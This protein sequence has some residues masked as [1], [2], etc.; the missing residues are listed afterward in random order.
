MAPLHDRPMDENGKSLQAP[1]PGSSATSDALAAAVREVAVAQLQVFLRATAIDEA[2]IVLTGG[3]EREIVATTGGLTGLVGIRCD[4]GTFA[5]QVCCSRTHA[6]M[7]EAERALLGVTSVAGCVVAPIERHGFVYGAFVGALR[8]AGPERTQEAASVAES[9]AIA[10]EALRTFSA[11]QAASIDVQFNDSTR[12][13]QSFSA[14]AA[15]QEAVATPQ[16]GDVF[17]EVQRAVRLAVPESNVVA[18]I[19]APSDAVTILPQLVSVDGAITWSSALRSVRVGDCAASRAL[20][21]G[22][23]VVSNAPV[24]SWAHALTDLGHYPPA[25]TSASIWTPMP[26]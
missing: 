6:E 10:F 19:L 24:R 22:S 2:L 16:L 14:V 5:D 13:A 17:V 8:D 20:A 23:V 25:S 9:T 1:A 21:T 18:L 11:T 4:G 26:H 15:M 12:R 7:S 3:V